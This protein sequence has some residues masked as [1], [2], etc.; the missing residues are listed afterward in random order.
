VV[1]VCTGPMLTKKEY[2]ELIEPV[3]K[4]IKAVE[5]YIKVVLSELLCLP[6][7]CYFCWEEV[8]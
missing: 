6:V 2:A 7:L 1:G 8:E 5:D 3:G 4:R